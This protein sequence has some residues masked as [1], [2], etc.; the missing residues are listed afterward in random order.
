MIHNI[1][2][3]YLNISISILISLFWM[4]HFEL[5]FEEVPS[6]LKFHAITYE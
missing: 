5:S 3:K 1:I 6:G 4:I 2:R